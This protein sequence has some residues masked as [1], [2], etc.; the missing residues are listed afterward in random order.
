MADTTDPDD[1][2][3]EPSE[4]RSREY[5]RLP[6]LPVGAL[7]R[8]ECVHHASTPANRRIRQLLRMLSAVSNETRHATA[9]SAQPDSSTSSRWL[10]DAAACRLPAPPPCPGGFGRIEVRRAQSRESVLLDP[11]AAPTES[12]QDVCALRT[13]SNSG[14]FPYFELP[15]L[16]FLL[17]FP[18][19]NFELS[20]FSRGPSCAD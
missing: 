1:V 17:H 14:V 20:T 3:T 6:W 7:D 8:S 5:R 9:R 18:T 16:H 19:L 4:R 11:R 15:P 12:V 10:P 13:W 2:G